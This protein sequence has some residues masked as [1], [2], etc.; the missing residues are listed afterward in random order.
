MKRKNIIIG[1]ILTTT[2]IF[3]FLGRSKLNQINKNKE[4]DKYISWFDEEV[5]MFS[6]SKEWEYVIAYVNN[7]PIYYKEIIPRAL[8]LQINNNVISKLS[9]DKI[10]LD[11]DMIDNAFSEIFISK[12]YELYFKSQNKDIDIESANANLREINEIEVNSKIMLT[13]CNA[14]IRSKYPELFKSECLMMYFNKIIQ[15][16]NEN[17]GLSSE[18]ILRDYEKIFQKIMSESVLKFEEGAPHTL[19][20]GYTVNELRKWNVKIYSHG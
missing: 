12:A 19:E 8:V 7:V 4:C 9:I 18:E 13:K 3:T 17:K 14:L 10:K 15:Q 6:R 16:E 1:I 2:I 20:N 5:K 11:D